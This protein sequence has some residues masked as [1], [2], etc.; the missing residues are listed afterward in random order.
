MAKSKISAETVPALIARTQLGQIMRRARRDHVRF[1]VEKRGEP[2]VVILGIKD[3]LA[4]LVPEA[5]VLAEIRSRSSN[6]GRNKITM[7]EIDREIAAS[8]RARRRKSA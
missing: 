8:R 7:S 1:V 6:A 2:Q 4:N 5:A 3:F